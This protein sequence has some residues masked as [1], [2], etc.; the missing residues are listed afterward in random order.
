M[1]EGAFFYA[2]DESTRGGYRNADCVF[3]V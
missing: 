1:T 3:R 2:T